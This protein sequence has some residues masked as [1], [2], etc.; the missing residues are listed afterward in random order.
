MFRNVFMRTTL[1]TFALV[2]VG[3]LALAAP[4]GAQTPPPAS[5][6][7][8]AAT[9]T[10]NASAA[11]KDL[12]GR[13]SDGAL[14]KL[15]RPGAFASDAAIRIGL[16]GGK[17][18]RDVVRLADRAGLG[19]NLE[20]LLNDAATSAAGAAKPIFRSAIDR[21]TLADAASMVRGSTGAT[22][23]LRKT[24]SDQVRAQLSPLVRSALDKSGALTQVSRLSALGITDTQLVSWVTEKTAD[25]V[26]LYMGKE[27]A[28][29]RKNPLAILGR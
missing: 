2:A 20:T 14:D 3:V 7:P 13:A 4:V 21:M 9:Q 18:V 29:L 8:P 22:D 24:A 26:F 25:G 1:R 11:V 19:G 15:A 12:L 16:P 10:R 27:E 28:A 5:P 6:K 17:S 23:Y